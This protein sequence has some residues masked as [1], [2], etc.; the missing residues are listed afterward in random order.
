MSVLQIIYA[1]NP[2][3][4]QVAKPIAKVDN[5]IRELAKDMLDTMYF[6]HAVGLGANMLGIDRRIVVID[7]QQNSVKNP[8]VMIN[9]EIINSSSSTCEFEEASISFPGISASISRPEKITVKYLN[10][11]GVEQTLEAD[12]FFARVIQHEIDYLNGKIFLDYVSKLKRDM[13]MKKML[14]YLKNNPPHIHGIH[15]HH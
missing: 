1:P 15:C 8:Y 2:V 10:L 5:E 3:F 9:P 4:K 13:L 14:K 6:E 7:L 12:G 11:D